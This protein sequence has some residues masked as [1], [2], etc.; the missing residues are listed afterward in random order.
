MYKNEYKDM[1]C[2]YTFIFISISVVMKLTFQFHSVD[3]CPEKGY[4]QYRISI[5]LLVRNRHR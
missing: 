4:T 2:R 3:A 5:L 1:L